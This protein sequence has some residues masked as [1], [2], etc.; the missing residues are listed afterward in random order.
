MSEYFDKIEDHCKK[1]EKQK[2]TV[3]SLTLNKMKDARVAMAKEASSFPTQAKILAK[4][5]Q[6]SGNNLSDKDNFF[7]LSCMN[8]SAVDESNFANIHLRTRR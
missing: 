5:Q 8:M 6:K 7:G 2:P 1:M 4:P 3:M